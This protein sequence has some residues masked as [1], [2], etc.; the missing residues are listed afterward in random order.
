MVRYGTTLVQKMSD[1]CVVPADPAVLLPIATRTD[2]MIE[3]LLAAH[4]NFLT[5]QNRLNVVIAQKQHL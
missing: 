4:M 2:F 5:W 1:V 3:N